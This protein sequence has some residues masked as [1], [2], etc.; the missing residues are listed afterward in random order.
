MRP[1]RSARPGPGLSRRAADDAALSDLPRAE[2][3]ALSDPPQ[4]RTRAR[5]HRDRRSAATRAG[6]VIYVS[7]HRAISTISRAARARR[8]R[9]PAADHRRRH[10]PVRRAARADSSPRH[11]RDPDPTQHE[12]SRLSDHAEGVRG[13]SCCS[14]TTCSS[15]SRA[16][17]A[18]AARSSRRRPDCCTRR[19]RPSRA[20][21]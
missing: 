7:N 3:S 14:A 1:A 11:R 12:G 4:D 19:F 17:A 20:T 10:Q 18:T 6:R 21:W 8:Q 2:A 13:A 16:G 15:T 9:H 5:A